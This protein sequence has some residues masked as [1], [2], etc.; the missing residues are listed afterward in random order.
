L[1]IWIVVIPWRLSRARAI[2]IG[3]CRVVAGIVV[4][5]WGICISIARIAVAITVAVGISISITVWVA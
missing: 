5:A 1:I 3:I 2:A 4:I